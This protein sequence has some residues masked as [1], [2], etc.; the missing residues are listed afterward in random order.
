MLQPPFDEKLYV[1]KFARLSRELHK[2]I[3]PAEHRVFAEQRKLGQG[4]NASFYAKLADTHL[5]LLREHL[6]GVDRICREVWKAQ[7]NSVSPEF[8]RTVIKAHIFSA[9]AA[10]AGSIKGHLQQMARRTRFTNMAAA[11]DHLALKRGQLESEWSER[12]ETEAIGLEHRARSKARKGAVDSGNDSWAATQA[13]MSQSVSSESSPAQIPLLAKKA[14]SNRGDHQSG[15]TNRSAADRG[16]DKETAHRVIRP[17]TKGTYGAEP[18]I[19]ENIDKLRK[20]CGWSFDEIAKE[21][22]IDKKLIWRHVNKGTRPTPRLLREYT[23]AFSR[24]L[25][26]N[27]TPLDLEK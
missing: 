5:A 10:R 12:Y 6:E 22:G 7:G 14:L 16:S 15:P 11:L 19:G 4:H 2:K 21:T 18:A 24:R 8:V 27:I 1:L 20:E 26:R 23:Q 25:G 9:I 3:Y 13:K 17:T